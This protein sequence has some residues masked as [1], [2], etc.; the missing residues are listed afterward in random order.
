MTKLHK[1]ITITGSS[2]TG[3]TTIARALATKENT[4]V[5]YTSREKR[6]GEVEDLDYYYRSKEEMLKMNEEG[7]FIEFIEFN[8]NF[9]GYTYDEIFNKLSKNDCICVITYDGL[10]ELYKIDKLKHIIKPFFLF[11]SEEK[12]T[13]NL[14]KRGGKK[15]VESR[16]KLYKQETINNFLFSLNIEN[17]KI[18]NTTF[19]NEKELISRL[20]NETNFK[21]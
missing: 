12:I 11:A 16:I 8:N 13:Q 17:A 7:K 9:Y 5:S 4:I 21:K 14:L 18:I 2:G 19:L 3:K 15:E 6:D 10:E 1:L 20:K